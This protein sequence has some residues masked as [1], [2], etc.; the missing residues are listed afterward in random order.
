MSV[1]RR[2]VRERIRRQKIAADFVAPFKR[3][4]AWVEKARADGRDVT[5]G[6]VTDMVR[7]YFSAPGEL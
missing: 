2:K 1:R 6:E 3:V 5:Q 7:R 4:Q